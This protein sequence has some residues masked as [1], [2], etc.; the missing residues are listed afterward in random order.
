MWG[1]FK[2][3]SDADAYGYA[4]T[5]DDAD[6]YGDVNA[7]GDLNAY[8]DVNNYTNTNSYKY[9]ISSFR[10]IQAGWRP[11]FWRW[12]TFCRSLSTMCLLW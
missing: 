11:V 5:H 8:G 1:D 12:N 3:D 9:T 7:Y 4:N 6:A 10:H 2:S